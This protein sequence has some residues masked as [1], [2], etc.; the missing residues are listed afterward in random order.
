[1]IGKVKTRHGNFLHDPLTRH[2]NNRFR[3]GTITN[4]V[5]QQEPVNHGSLTGLHEGDTRV[6]CFDTLRKELF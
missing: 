6:T 2:E 5:T 3:V 4:R 1:M